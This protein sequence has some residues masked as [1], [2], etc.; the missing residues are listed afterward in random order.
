MSDERKRMWAGEYFKILL[1]L[2]PRQKQELARIKSSK[3]GVARIH[4]RIEKALRGKGLIELRE[5]GRLYA[6]EKGMGPL[7]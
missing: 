6:T 2:T 4:Q 5:D 1:S 3:N 7:Y